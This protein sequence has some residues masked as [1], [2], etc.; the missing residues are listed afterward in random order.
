MKKIFQYFPVFICLMALFITPVL[1]L[2]GSS[3]SDNLKFVGEEGNA[4]YQRIVKDNNDLASIVGTVIEAF[5]GILG[6]LFLVYMIYAGYNWLT[7]QGEEEK[8]TKA[9]ETIQRAIIGLIVT[10]AAYAISVWVFDKI[11]DTTIVS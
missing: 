11:L 3:A 5:L 7:A 9:K 8:V 1:A 4:P 10:I 6:V 2:A